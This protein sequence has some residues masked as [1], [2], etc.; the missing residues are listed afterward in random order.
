[1]GAKP[2]T[3]IRHQ[4]KLPFLMIYLVF[5]INFLDFI[6]TIM[7]YHRHQKH[8]ITFLKGMGSGPKPIPGNGIPCFKLNGEVGPASNSA[9]QVLYRFYP[10]LCLQECKGHLIHIMNISI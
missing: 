1:M 7:Q 5:N 3:T 6:I 8:M 10:I 9:I 4:I 2:N